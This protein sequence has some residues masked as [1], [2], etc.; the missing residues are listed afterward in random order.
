MPTEPQNRHRFQRGGPMIDQMC[1]KLI[2]GRVCCAVADA[3]IHQMGDIDRAD[4][5]GTATMTTDERE[6][7]ERIRIKASR[8]PRSYPS[9]LHFLL[10]LL[11]KT[12]SLI[13]EGL[14]CD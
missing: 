9:D 7:L 8:E 3:E 5:Q 11:N 2:D 6:R 10:S 1:G 4:E 14:D 12:L 13:P